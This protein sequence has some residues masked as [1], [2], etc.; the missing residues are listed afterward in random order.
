MGDEVG[1]SLEWERAM[2]LLRPRLSGTERLCR[3]LGDRY[4][5][6]YEEDSPA[7]QEFAS[8][9]WGELKGDES[10]I[11]TAWWQAMVL[12]WAALDGI[13]ALERLLRDVPALYAPYPVV[14]SA[15]EM[16]ARGW[17]LLDPRV[18]ASGRAERA[19]ALRLMYLRWQM[20][21]PGGDQDHLDGRFR[22]LLR[23]CRLRDVPVQFASDG[24]PS[25]IGEV[26]PPTNRVQ[27]VQEMLRDNDLG[28][29]LYG[30]LSSIAHG[31]PAA[32][33]RALRPE[34]HPDGDLPGVV[35]LRVDAGEA[36]T[37]VVSTLYGF[38][39]LF[40]RLVTWLGWNGDRWRRWM[41]FTWR[42]LLPTFEQDG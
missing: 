36:R 6:H 25:K 10:P 2:A 9:R 20:G 30:H 26:D 35:A 16:S 28:L 39:P 24:Q 4:S 38:E 15:I 3:E 18:G 37:L 5:W 40:D 23:T 32:L 27:L 13:V 42:K 17:W 7:A 19:L 41:Q 22:S 12:V 1:V 8:E 14:R 34:R 11:R 33:L 21:M 29:A 31:D